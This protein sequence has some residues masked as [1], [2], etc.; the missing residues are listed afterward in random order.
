MSDNPA[1][2][3]YPPTIVSGHLEALVVSPEPQ[4]DVHEGLGFA[5]CTSDSYSVLRLSSVGVLH[6][7][8]GTKLP[9]EPQPAIASLGSSEGQS[10]SATP[11]QQGPAW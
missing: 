3:A 2:I 7:K 9:S 6:V 10:L 5:C 11:P 8:V 1:S 4:Q